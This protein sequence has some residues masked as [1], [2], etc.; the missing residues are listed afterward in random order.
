LGEDAYIGFSGEFV[1]AGTAAAE[2]HLGLICVNAADV[3]M[4]FIQDKFNHEL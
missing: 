1:L 4:L 3:T 2:G